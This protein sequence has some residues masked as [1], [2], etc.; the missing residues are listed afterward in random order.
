MR[1]RESYLREVKVKGVDIQGA[2]NIRCL[3]NPIIISGLYYH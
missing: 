2:R 3:I 1:T